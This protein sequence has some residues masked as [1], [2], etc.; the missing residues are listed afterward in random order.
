MKEIEKIYEKVIEQS[1]ENVNALG[2][3]LRALDELYADIESLKD[4]NAEIPLLFEKKYL[5]IA[6][7][8]QKFTNTIGE[9]TKLYIEGNNKTFI[10]NIRKLAEENKNLRDTSNDIERETIRLENLDFEEPFDKFQKTLS[11]IFG[12]I[13][14]V[15]LSMTEIHQSMNKIVK[16]NNDISNKIDKVKNDLSND[17]SIQSNA[18]K[19]SNTLINN[20]VGEVLD[21]TN[22]TNKELEGVKTILI[23]G[24]ILIVALLLYLAFV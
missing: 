15:N 24:L 23:I 16:L 9:S 7:L 5:E 6:E 12:A 1:Q 21:S 22:K 18:I 19:N 13:N 17:I 14:T 8:S 3:K 10:K 2:E 20:K 4:A 11:D